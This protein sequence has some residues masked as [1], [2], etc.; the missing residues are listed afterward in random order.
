MNKVSSH[1]GIAGFQALYKITYNVPA[2][3]RYF[4]DSRHIILQFQTYEYGD[5]YLRERETCVATYS[6][7]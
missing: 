7:T 6:K 4:K 3:Y 5:I 1:I 2:L